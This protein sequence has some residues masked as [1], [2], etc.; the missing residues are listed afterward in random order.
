MASNSYDFEEISKLSA[1]E[2]F[3]LL[4]G[5]FGASF[6]LFALLALSSIPASLFMY[7]KLN[8]ERASLDRNAAVLQNDIAKAAQVTLTSL[9]SVDQTSRDLLS[10]LSSPDKSLNRD[11]LLHDVLAIQ[12]QLSEARGSLFYI[13][14]S[15]R[16][17]SQSQEPT[18][19]LI[20][21]ARADA[22]PTPTPTPTSAVSPPR[23]V[24]DE[25]RTW[26]MCLVFVVLGI[27]FIISI[28]AIFKTTNADVL[29]FAFDTVKTLLGFF[30]GVATT[31]IGT[32]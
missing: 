30:I 2:R 4:F 5:S 13:L 7:Y 21:S 20:T 1:I 14:N 26:I 19:S 31:L 25:M 16:K 15:L 24:S 9:D 6:L 17:F 10:K 29:K 22:L 27:T 8:T 11:E 18:F 12:S 3:K 32:T 23:R 28:V